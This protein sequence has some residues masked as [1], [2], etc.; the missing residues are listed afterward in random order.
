MGELKF[1]S[2]DPVKTKEWARLT[3]MQVTEVKNRICRYC[4]HFDAGDDR[5]MGSRYCNFFVDEG[6]CRCCSPLEC[7]EKGYFQ[8]GKRP[9]RRV[10]GEAIRYL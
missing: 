3:E 7:K 2:F 4:I 5:Q 8:P 1:K 10:V 6:H 9:Q